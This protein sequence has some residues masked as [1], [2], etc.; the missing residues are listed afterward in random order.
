MWGLQLRIGQADTDVPCLDRGCTDD[1]AIDVICKVQLNVENFQGAWREGEGLERLTVL[2]V[3]L[4][5][6]CVSYS[7]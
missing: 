7:I 2:N 5:I 1:A 6:T 3:L 4:S